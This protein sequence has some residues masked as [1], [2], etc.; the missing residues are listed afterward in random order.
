MLKEEMM[1]VSD[2]VNFVQVLEIIGQHPDLLREHVLSIH[3]VNSY[4]F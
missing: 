1:I 4:H 2:E 3:P